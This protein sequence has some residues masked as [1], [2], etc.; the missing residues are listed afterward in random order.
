MISWHAKHA[1]ICRN[2]TLLLDAADGYNLIDL[3]MAGQLGS[4][5]LATDMELLQV[6]P[7]RPFA[8][9]EMCAFKEA[10]TPAQAAA[11]AA[12]RRAGTTDGEHWC[13]ICT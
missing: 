11:A 12:H 7:L 1:W 9:G 10:L 3:E 6:K 8:A 4:P 13:S 5:L 2:L